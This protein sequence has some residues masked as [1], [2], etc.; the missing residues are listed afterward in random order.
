MVQ[1][2]QLLLVDLL[3]LVVLHLLDH[4]LSLVGL[5]NLVGL[6]DL[7]HLH[8][9]LTLVVPLHQLPLVDLHLLD[10]LL[11][12]AGLEGLEYLVLQSILVRQLLLV[13]LLNLV[14][15]HLLD[16]LL[17]L[18]GLELLVLQ[19]I[20]A[21]QLLLVD[22]LNLV[23]LHLLDLLLNLE[24]QLIL[25]DLL[26]PVGLVLQLNQLLLVLQ[27]C[28]AGLVRLLLRHF[29]LL[30]HFLLDLVDLLL[31]LIPVDLARLLNL[32]RQ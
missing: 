6:E 20:L 13:D 21:R 14:V 5:G 17:N 12:L 9:L 31:P 25:E 29:H 8:L 15:L 10:R 2:I 26:I 28:P 1:L 7:E 19:S 30:H 22:L 27:V 24:G 11:N 3:N 23:V 4:P 16:L 32:E 18:E